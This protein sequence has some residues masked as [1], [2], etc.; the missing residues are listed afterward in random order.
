MNIECYITDGHKDM[1][2]GYGIEEIADCIVPEPPPM[3]CEPVCRTM[4]E[5]YKL[6]NVGELQEGV[7]DHSEE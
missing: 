6:E 1:N 5:Q 2:S 3:T 7:I 4:N